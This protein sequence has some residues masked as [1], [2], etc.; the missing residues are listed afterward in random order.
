MT[1]DSPS[2]NSRTII[3][4]TITETIAFRLL[5]TDN[6]VDAFDVVVRWRAGLHQGLFVE[7]PVL[8]PSKLVQLQMAKG[9]VL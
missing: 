1:P 3:A 7:I 5:C 4:T 2:Y 6:P 8:S 9:C